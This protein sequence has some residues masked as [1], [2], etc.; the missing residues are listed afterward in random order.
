MARPVRVVI[1][2]ELVEE[3]LAGRMTH[4]QVAQT[5]GVARETVSRA[6]A[7]Q[8]LTGVNRCGGPK[9]GP[10]PVVG[11]LRAR[12]ADMARDRLYSGHSYEEIGKKYGVSRQRAHEIV[13][14]FKRRVGL[15]RVGW[16]EAVPCA[17]CGD[18]LAA[19]QIKSPA[20]CYRCWLQLPAAET[21]APTGEE[22]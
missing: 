19:V 22:K 4:R 10:I 21:A 9:R 7:R 5:M 1:P 2:M 17:G 3:Y 18:P 16:L 15:D 6:L 20:Y 12:A 14:S 8:G 11:S 13:S